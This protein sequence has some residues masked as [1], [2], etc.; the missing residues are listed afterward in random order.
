MP[1]IDINI[2]DI[3]SQVETQVQSLALATVSKYKDQAI[4]AGKQIVAD[5]KDD[6]TRWSQMLANKQLSTDEFEL[7]VKS[8]EVQVAVAGLEQAGLAE[9]RAYEFGMGVLN[10]IIDVVMKVA[11]AAAGGLLQKIS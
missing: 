5:M 9:V 1:T 3:L 7:L 6:L 4:A 11:Q 8:Y 2:N 10:V